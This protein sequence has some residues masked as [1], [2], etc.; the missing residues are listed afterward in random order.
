M[1]PHVEKQHALITYFK[2]TL[3]LD[4][5]TIFVNIKPVITGRMNLGMDQRS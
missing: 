3:F 1:D 5:V 4:S 2:C